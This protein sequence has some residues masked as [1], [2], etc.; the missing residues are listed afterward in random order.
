[1]PT[2]PAAFKYNRL[3]PVDE[4]MFKTSFA[5]AVPCIESLV[6]GELVPMPT[7]DDATPPEP[8]EVP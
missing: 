4:A 3:A 5:P 6:R 7:P 8:L 2:F 1:M